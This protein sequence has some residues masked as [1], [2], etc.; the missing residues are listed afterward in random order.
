MSLC[1]F[2]IGLSVPLSVIIIRLIDK[3]VYDM[4]MLLEGLLAE[5]LHIPSL[6]S[7]S[8]IKK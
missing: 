4:P 8:L 5:A 6:L 1:S 7:Q 2:L 3:Y